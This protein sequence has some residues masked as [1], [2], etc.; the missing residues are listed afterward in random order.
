[1]NGFFEDRFKNLQPSFFKL[2]LLLDAFA[3][4]LNETS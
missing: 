2:E 1:M 3:D 4:E